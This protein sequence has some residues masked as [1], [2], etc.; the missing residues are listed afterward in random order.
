[1]ATQFTPLRSDRHSGFAGALPA[2]ARPRP[3]TC[4]H[5]LEA[6]GTPWR[7]LGP[8]DMGNSAPSLGTRA[9]RCQ[10]VISLNRAVA[11]RNAFPSLCPARLGCGHVLRSR[12]L[13]RL[14]GLS[15]TLRDAGA[16]LSATPPG[17]AKELT[18]RELVHRPHDSQSSARCRRRIVRRGDIH[19]DR[20]LLVDRPLGP[21]R[22][23]VL[24]G[25]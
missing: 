3:P 5:Q 2:R 12:F 18:C 17:S 19:R 10:A 16:L 22:A 25:V 4:S 14:V 15:R 6:A 8:W 7:R 21:T 11:R 24:V 9:G 20:S 13:D 23:A 1:M